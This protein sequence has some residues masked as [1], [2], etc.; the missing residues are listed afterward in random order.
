MCLLL[1]YLS[2]SSMDPQAK[3]KFASSM[4]PV[5]KLHETYGVDP[6]VAFMLCRPLIRKALFFKD[7]KMLTSEKELPTYLKPFA[8]SSDEGHP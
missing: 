4:P 5:M 1:E 8:S 3:E 6:A 2:D 7:D